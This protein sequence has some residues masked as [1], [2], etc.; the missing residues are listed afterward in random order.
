MISFVEGALEAVGPDHVVVRVGGV[1]LQVFVSA[2]TI[3]SIGGPGQQLRLQ[4]HFH[5][6]EES[7]ALYGFETLEELKL[8]RMLLNVAGMGP[9]TSLSALGVM[10]PNDLAS[11]ILSEDVQALTRVPGVGRRTAAR[12]VLELKGSLEKDWGVMAG[13]AAA[14]PADPDAIEALVA[15]GYGQSEARAAVG[16]VEGGASMPLEEQVRQALQ[17]LGRG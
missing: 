13:A 15:L 1:G 8:F 14:G 9:R 6:K 10:P 3:G 16:A 12:I 4:T 5:F 11:A 17:R 2:S 7:M